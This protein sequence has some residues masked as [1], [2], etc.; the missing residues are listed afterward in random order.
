MPPFHSTNAPSFKPSPGSIDLC[1]CMTLEDGLVLARSGGE[2]GDF[3]GF[4]LG[5]GVD[6]PTGKGI[7][8]IILWM[9]P[10]SWRY[11]QI[12][13]AVNDQTIIIMT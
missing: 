7:M 8:M 13:Q 10:K 12:I 9:F 5:V 3:G 2:I 4:L 6:V 1:F 11:P